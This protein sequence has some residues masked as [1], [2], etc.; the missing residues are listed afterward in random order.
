[1]KMFKNKNFAVIMYFEII[2]KVDVF[3]IHIKE[4]SE[5]MFFLLI[6]IK[7]KLVIKYSVRKMDNFYFG[8]KVFHTF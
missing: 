7:L 4:I 3:V 8:H 6:I 2:F 1:M 5:F